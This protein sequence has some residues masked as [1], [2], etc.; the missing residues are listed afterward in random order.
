MGAPLYDITIYHQGKIIQDAPIDWKF[1]AKANLIADFYHD[2]LSGYKPKNTGRICVIFVERN[3]CRNPCY[4]GS[5]CNYEIT[6]DG[7]MYLGL[8]ETQQNK[9]I[10]GLLHSAIMDL[11]SIYGWEKECFQK[12]YDYIVQSDFRFEKT[13]PSKYSPDKKYSGCV[14][15]EKTETRTRLRVIISGGKEIN[16]VILEKRNWYWYDSA[17]KIAKKC[18]WIDKHSFGYDNG[19]AKFLLDISREK[20]VANFVFGERDF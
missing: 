5:I 2:R 7:D 18:K 12:A 9:Y 20:V 16:K 11:A 1:R 14:V 13:Y 19:D 6:V 8:C 10:L 4:F 17:Y 3:N 15:I